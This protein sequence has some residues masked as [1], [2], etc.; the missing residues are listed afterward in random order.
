MFFLI[1]YL[2]DLSCITP[3]IK[4]KFV[5]ICLITAIVLTPAFK[6]IHVS[7][8]DPSSKQTYNP[9]LFFRYYF[10]RFDANANCH[11]INL[12]LTNYIVLKYNFLKNYV[13]F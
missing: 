11:I 9:K 8:L 7:M 10:Y 1:V 12:L 4:K 3:I 5:A 13:F 2:I 6:N